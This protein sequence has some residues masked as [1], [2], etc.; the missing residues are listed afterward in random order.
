MSRLWTTVLL[1]GAL[2]CTPSGAQPSSAADS[3]SSGPT[4]AGDAGK[5]APGTPPAPTCFTNPHTYLE[6]I[7]ACTDAQAIDKA[8]DLSPMT[9]PDG[10]LRPLP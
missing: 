9:L 7:N 3:G 10:A 1:A 6:I 8:D 2:G 5:D 4:D